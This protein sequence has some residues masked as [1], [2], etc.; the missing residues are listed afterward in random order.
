MELTES[1]D[2]TFTCTLFA[3]TETFE[4]LSKSSQNEQLAWFKSNFSDALDLIGADALLRDLER[5]PRSPLISI[6]VRVNYLS[7]HDDATDA[8]TTA[9]WFR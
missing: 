1:Q 8:S 7:A 5:N 3:P 6:K 4:R 9:R 2:R